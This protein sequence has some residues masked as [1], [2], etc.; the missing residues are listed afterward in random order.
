[1]SGQ[2]PISTNGPV[3]FDRVVQSAIAF[4]TI[5]E[6]NVLMVFSALPSLPRRAAFS[7]DFGVRPATARARQ[8]TDTLGDRRCALLWSRSHESLTAIASR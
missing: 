3:R 1:M 6:G 7:G 2:Y 8:I 5:F 4:D